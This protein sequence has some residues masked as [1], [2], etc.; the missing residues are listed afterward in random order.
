MALSKPFKLRIGIA[1][2]A[3]LAALLLYHLLL[4]S[5][6]VRLFWLPLVKKHTGVE[7]RAETCSVSLFSTRTLSAEQVSVKLPGWNA[8]AAQFSLSA[9]PL[10]FLT[11]GTLT[12]SDLRIAGLKLEEVRSESPSGPGHSRRAR[13]VRN[14]EAGKKKKVPGNILLRKAVLTDASLIFSDGAGTRYEFSDLDLVCSDVVPSGRAA[15]RF[16]SQFR[17]VSGSMETSRTSVFGNARFELPADSLIP[18]G[19]E[20]NFSSGKTTV[21]GR[22]MPPLEASLA[23]CLNAGWNNGRLLVRSSSLHLKDGAGSDVLNAAFDG[24]FHPESYT[25]KLSASLTTRRSELQDALIRTFSGK[26]WKNVS[27]TAKVTASIA[28]SGEE[29]TAEGSADLS[30]DCL[31]GEIRSLG[32]RFSFRGLK[33]ENELQLNSFRFHLRDG[34]GKRSLSA[35]TSADFL[36]KYDVRKKAVTGTGSLE[37]RTAD[38][39]LPEIAGLLNASG[40][41]PLKSGLFSLALKAAPAG[42]GVV[43]HGNASLKKFLSSLGDVP[44]APLD[45]ASVFSLKIGME[46]LGIALES[47]RLTGETGHRKFLVAD[48]KFSA[49]DLKAGFPMT[50]EAV[51]SELN[52]QLFAVVPFRMLRNGSVSRLKTEMNAGWRRENNDYQT[53]SVSGTV[54]GLSAAEA[55]PSL[56]LSFGSR[57]ALKEN[58]L[59]IDALSLTA[60]EQHRDFLD[61]NLSGDL[62]LPAGDGRSRLRIASQFLDAEK[63]QRLVR[64][65]NPGSSPP[66]SV[67]AGKPRS[68]PER[69]PRKEPAPL[70]L[71]AYNGIVDFAFEKIQYTDDVALSLHG[72]LEIDGSRIAA[73][74][75]KLSANGSPVNLRFSVDTGFADGY[76]YDLAFSMKNLLLPPLIKAAMNGKDYG[77]T[78]TIASV[79]LKFEGKGFAPLNFKKNLKGRVKASTADLSFPAPSAEVID[80]LNL[81]FIPLNAVPDLTDAL[82]LDALTGDLKTLSDNVSG[83]LDGSK[84]VEFDQG[85]MDV[86]VSEGIVFLNQFLFEGGTLKSENLTG[87]VN[88]LTGGLDLSASLNLGLLVIPMKLGGTFARPRPDYKDF[89]VQFTKENVETLLDPDNME[90]TIKNVDSILKLF[91]RKKKK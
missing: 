20:I 23:V 24:G 21:S 35:G 15:V 5:I 44:A 36:W 52:E 6:A 87:K 78:G 29:V 16:E 53:F 58:N 73:E 56:E 55:E 54:D 84:N 34:S 19:M 80:A 45:L 81:L 77:V 71:S 47:C 13:R 41:F 65:L 30:A 11:S 18:S 70:D 40:R 90:N 91:Q 86:S 76:V 57:V 79:D 46:P 38:L 2:T 59:R 68:S 9:N 66:A 63:L 26:P 67:S 17:L 32:S 61:L 39:D 4:S 31:F 64:Q 51:V 22:G 48:L 27:F 69:L 1:A 10:Q 74:S 88:L 43:L 42:N 3:V 12:V 89:L 85:T 14:S 72:P 37:L 25:G 49:P 8:T 33:R 60:S 50:A 82:N 7:V 83:I 28:D 75:L 62:R